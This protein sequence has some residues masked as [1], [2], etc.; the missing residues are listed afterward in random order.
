MNPGRTS[1]PRRASGVVRRSDLSPTGYRVDA[2]R[3]LDLQA[4]QLALG[5]DSL[6]A[7]IDYAVTK[8]LADMEK[9]TEYKAISRA[10]R[11]AKRK[12]S[13]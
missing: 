9:D 3:K 2:Q 7:V 13:D 10:A 5:K 4:A 11:R 1:P 12:R 8:L 6:Q